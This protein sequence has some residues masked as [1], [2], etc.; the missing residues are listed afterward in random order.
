[1]RPTGD[2]EWRLCRITPHSDTPPVEVQ[3]ET[4]KDDADWKILDMPPE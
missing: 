1:M 2:G 4:L 3:F